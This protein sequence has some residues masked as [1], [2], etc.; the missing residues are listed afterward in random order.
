MFGWPSDRRCSKSCFAKFWI[1]SPVTDDPE[2]LGSTSPGDQRLVS[3][4]QVFSGL[5]KE[6]A[7]INDETHEVVHQQRHQSQNR[8]IE[9]D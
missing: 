6:L 5:F 3:L 2:V 4:K 7:A 9:F 8:E 1:D